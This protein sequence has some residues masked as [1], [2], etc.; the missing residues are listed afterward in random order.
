MHKDILNNFRNIVTNNNKIISARLN[1]AYFTKINQLQLWIDWNL[2]TENLKESYSKISYR[3]IVADEF[4]TPPLC[5]MCNNIPRIIVLDEANNHKAILSKFCGHKCASKSPTKVAKMKESL[6]KKSKEDKLASNKL[7]EVTMIAKYGHAY[8]LQRP[9]VMDTI[10]KSQRVDDE[11]YNKLTNFDWVNEHYINQKKSLSM[12]GHELGIYYGT[13]GEYV[14]KLGFEIHYDFHDSVEQRIIQDFLDE[15]S[16]NYIRN[17]IKTLKPRELDF[18]LEE[19]NLA[20]EI[21][22]I[23]WHC[24]KFERDP[25]R[26]LAKTKSCAKLG[27]RLIHFTCDQINNNL[28]LVKSII[29]HAINKSIRIA[30]RKCVVKVID[31][32]LII[33]NFLDTNHIQGYVYAKVSLGLYHNNVLVAMMTFGEPRFNKKFEWELIRYCNIANHNVMGGAGKILK[34]FENSYNPKSLISYCNKMKYTGNLYTSLGLSLSHTSKPSYI[35]VRDGKV[36]S[37]YVCNKSNLINIIGDNFDESLSENSNMINAG[38]FKYWD[39]GNLVF[40]KEY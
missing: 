3:M 1:V 23:Y 8:N 33:K 21:N 39:C 7:R 32:K 26:H 5:T 15:L 20:I 37:R 16:I 9:T 24:D 12:L 30:A 27:I 31:D 36:Y 4:I 25:Y 38:Y 2:L 29:K 40:K 14:K 19:F 22:G 6:S 34:Y 18:Y 35:W 13:V 28:D 17:D 10:I 11:I